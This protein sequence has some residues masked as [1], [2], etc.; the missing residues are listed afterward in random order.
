[1]SEL[2]R[3]TTVLRQAVG[4]DLIF[5]VEVID[6]KDYQGDVAKED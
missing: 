5:E 2:S 3:P 6:P 4:N 1:L